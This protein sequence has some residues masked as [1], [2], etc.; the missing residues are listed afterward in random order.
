MT[1]N[2]RPKDNAGVHGGGGYEFQKICALYLL[3]DSYSEL[4]EKEY[5]IYFE[6]FDDFVFCFTN[7]SNIQ[8]A[9]LYQAKKNNDKW[10]L[11]TEFKNTIQAMCEDG[12]IARSDT[13]FI[14][15][16]EYKQLL[17]FVSNAVIQL[18]Q[19]K[20]NET[21]ETNCFNELCEAAQKEISCHIQESI[22]YSVFSR[23]SSIKEPSIA[24]VKTWYDSL[25][26]EQKKAI[27]DE[28]KAHPV[29]KEIPNLRFRY[30]DLGKKTSSQKE[31]LKGKLTTIFNDHIAHPSA[32]IDTLLL[33]FSEPATSFNQGCITYSNRSKRVSSDR[34]KQCFEILTS[35]SMAINDWRSRGNEISR[36][37]RLPLNERA[38]FE[39]LFINSLDLFKDMEQ[40]EHLKILTFANEMYKSLVVYDID[41]FV[42]ETYERYVQKH[43]SRFSKIELQA[44]IYA[45]Y[46][47][48][49]KPKINE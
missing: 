2:I 26:D 48:I 24:Q 33:L 12:V 32:A 4:K 20:T 42:N 17:H 34:V 25:D 9:H 35:Q 5:F 29:V 38:I 11:D 37:L 45:A 41:S 6:H 36:N 31:Q 27:D 22:K 40:V 19:T 13:T 3:L 16:A 18:K 30:I 1:T 44:I 15:T 39:R 23:E 8:S 21:K 7:D 43:S 47:E 28:I 49:V 14:K 10:T 46:F